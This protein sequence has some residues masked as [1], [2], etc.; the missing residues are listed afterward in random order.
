MTDDKPVYGS[1]AGGEANPNPT[2]SDGP[3][4]WRIIMYTILFSS[5]LIVAGLLFMRL[6]R[7]ER[8]NQN[9]HQSLSTYKD[10]RPWRKNW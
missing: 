1:T 7:K 8:R 3:G 9:N 6:R 2:G 5:I 10:P 4:L